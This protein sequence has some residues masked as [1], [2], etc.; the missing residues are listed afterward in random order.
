MAAPRTRFGLALGYPWHRRHHRSSHPSRLLWTR[1]ARVGTGPPRTTKQ[2]V[3]GSSTLLLQ[4]TIWNLPHD[5]RGMDHKSDHGIMGLCPSNLEG[6]QWSVPWRRWTRTTSKTLRRSQWPHYQIVLA[7]P[8]SP[9]SSLHT[10][11]QKISRR[12]SEDI[13]R[14]QTILAAL[15]WRSPHWISTKVS[16]GPYPPHFP[17]AVE[18]HY[19]IYPTTFSTWQHPSLTT[20]PIWSAIL[21]LILGGARCALPNLILRCVTWHVGGAARRLH[22][23]WTTVCAAPSTGEETPSVPLCIYV[24]CENLTTGTTV[25]AVVES[26]TGVWL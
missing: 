7:G 26:Y 25:F 13:R 14:I 1:T 5:G 4:W 3:G 11:L 17:T 24:P 21:I 8:I 18:G 19:Y 22:V 20:V 15:R 10:P 16:Y 23:T 9:S 12:Y 2:K 6:T